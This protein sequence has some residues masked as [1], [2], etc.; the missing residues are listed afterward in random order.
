MTSKDAESRLALAE[1]IVREAG[2]LLLAARHDSRQIDFKGEI[3]LVTEMDRRSEA[4]IVGE[5]GRHFPGIPVLA[6]EGLAGA[7]APGGPLWILDP[8]DGTTNY[9]HGFPVF[10]VS[11]ALESGGLELGIVHDPTRDETFTA[12][13]GGGARLNGRPIAVTDR[14]KLAE[15]LIATGFPYDIRTSPDNN[16]RQFNALALRARGI[17]RAGAA[18]LDLAYVAAGRFDGYWEEKIAVWDVAAGTLIVREA[19]GRVTDY[20]GREVDI[21]GRRIVA[22]NGSI[23]EELVAALAAVERAGA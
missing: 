4:F 9:A 23:H 22:T 7:A 6:E 1:S 18:A 19:G 17:R 2:R 8:L 12:V 20:A 16:L 5:L 13:R 10:A 14:R 15:S 21:R 11:L 3:D